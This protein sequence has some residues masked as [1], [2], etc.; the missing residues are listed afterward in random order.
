MLVS[1]HTALR[2][3]I[4]SELITAKVDEY[5]L[6][7]PP[8]YWVVASRCSVYREGCPRDLLGD[9]ISPACVLDAEECSRITTIGANATTANGVPCPRMLSQQPCSWATTPQ[10]I[11]YD[12][13]ALPNGPLDQEYP[14][15]CGAGILGSDEQRFQ[16]PGLYGG[17]VR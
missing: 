6:P 11:G 1:A 13:H 8:G 4:Y 14:Y 3:L 7:A 2:D 12:V 9:I 17:I 5:A 16:G 10:L 15:P